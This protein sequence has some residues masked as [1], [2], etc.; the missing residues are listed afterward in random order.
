MI[1]VRI[2]F[3]NKKT[4]F[5]EDDIK[6]DVP[7]DIVFR[8]AKSSDVEEINCFMFDVSEEMKSYVIKNYPDLKEKFEQYE[9][10]FIGRHGLG[11]EYD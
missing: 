1:T 9:Y 4:R 3:Y 6:I 7:D 11:P 2:V 8:S 10:D 5:A